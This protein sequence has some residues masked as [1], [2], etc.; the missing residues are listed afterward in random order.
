MNGPSALSFEAV[1]KRYDGP[2]PVRALG[3]VT[4]AV[5]AGSFVLIEG[6]SGSG[7]TTLLALAGG[8]DLPS[9]GRVLV[10]GLDLTSQSMRSLAL[11]RRENVGFV[12]QDFRLIDVLTALENVALA[13]QVRG[14]GGAA[15]RARGREVLDR[16]GMG[17]RGSARPGELSGGE[18]QRVAIARALV[19]GPRL[20]LADEPTANLDWDNG[21]PVVE[22]LR[23]AAREQRAAVLVASH[24]TRLGAYADQV[25]RLEDGR[26]AGPRPVEVL[27]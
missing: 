4:F 15:A 27:T 19:T 22:I 2:V 5:E 11:F 21:E 20:V 16:L 1:H 10:G 25:I 17:D 3:G 7:K 12:F 26:I 13:L 14:V 6:P 8:L 9:S 23:A 24:D 18:K